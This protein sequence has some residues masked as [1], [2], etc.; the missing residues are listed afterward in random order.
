MRKPV[1]YRSPHRRTARRLAQTL[2][3]TDNRRVPQDKTMRDLRTS[4]RWAARQDE[5]ILAALDAG[6]TPTA[7]AEA[8]GRSRQHVYNV[9]AR[10]DQARSPWPPSHEPRQRMGM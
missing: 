4:A 10:R 2:T 8:A 5:L 3:L 1:D 9:L 6:H 7:V